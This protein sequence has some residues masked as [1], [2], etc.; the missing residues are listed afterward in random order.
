MFFE[1]IITCTD[2]LFIICLMKISPDHDVTASTN[3]LPIMVK[4][5]RCVALCVPANIYILN[6]FLYNSY[7]V[8]IEEILKAIEFRISRGLIA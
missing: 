1:F 2:N 4:R 7:T 8:E 5:D 6:K 3:T